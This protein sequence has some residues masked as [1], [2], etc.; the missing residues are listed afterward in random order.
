MVV[1]ERRH[2]IDLSFH[3]DEVKLAKKMMDTLRTT[4]EFLYYLM[5]HRH[6]PAFTMILLSTENLHLGSLLQQWKRQTDIL[7]EIDK[8]NNIYIIICQ[9]TD[10]EGARQFAEIILSNISIYK[11]SSTYCVATELNSTHNSIQDVVFKMVEKY[12]LIKQK[13]EANKI[14]FTRV[15]KGT[16]LF[17]SNITYTA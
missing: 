7:V 3:E 8:E 13:E 1:E 6:T 2:I 16:K 4:M 15:M 5:E 12:M 11:G 17:D 14:Y 10:A 9:A